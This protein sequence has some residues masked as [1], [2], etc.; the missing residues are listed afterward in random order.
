MS[1]IDDQVPVSPASVPPPVLGERLQ[2]ARKARGLTQQEVA[3]KLDLVRTTLVAIEKGERRVQSGELI[4]MAKLY[5]RPVGDFVGRKANLTPFAPQFRLPHA[6]TG[7][8]EAELLGAVAD[9]ESL[10]QDYLELEEINGLSLRPSFPPEYQ[11]DIPGVSPEHLGEDIAAAERT[12]LGVGDG[13]ISDLRALLEESVGIRIFYLR[14]PSQ[15]GGLFACND[16]LGACVAINSNHPPQRGNWSLAH[17]YA[18]FLTTR[19]QAD[20]DLMHGS[21]GKSVAERFADSF[22]KNF[23]M[24]RSGVTR[25]LSDSVQAHGKGVSVADVLSLAT[26]YRVSA[27]A[28]F[29]RLEE[30]K[31]LSSGTWE[32]L[33][34]RGFRPDQAR[35]NLGL[36]T[37]AP[38]PQPLPLR[39]R[40]LA[41]NAFVDRGEL[42]EGQLAKKLRM[43]RVSARLEL[44]NLSLLVD[45][46][47]T[48]SYE[49]LEL[50]DLVNPVATP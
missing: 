42:T 12:R 32:K 24:P 15:V 8:S 13:P 49:P 45:S 2:R 20:A 36:L 34:S 28:M 17:E 47:A 9:L 7:V 23:L 31:R 38:L 35:R 21:W 48:D 40:L 6:A 3:N 25:R 14:L 5:G 26:F 27:E 41:K 30:L 16:E 43:D 39:Y 37:L 19:Y 18:H 33:L 46:A 22:A 29:R 44:E 10:A 4:K 50:P 1:V 11:L